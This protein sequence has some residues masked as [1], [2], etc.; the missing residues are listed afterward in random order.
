MRAVVLAAGRGSRLGVLTQD[1][2]KCFTPFR[3]RPLIH[4]QLEA[5]SQAGVSEIGVARGY[6]AEFWDRQALPVARYFTNPRWRETNMVASLA[7]AA[8]WLEQGPCLVSYSDIFY[9]ADSV[10]RLQDAAGDIVITY[11]PNWLELWRQRFADPLVDAETFRIDPGGR[12]L[13]IGAKPKSLAE[14][15]GQYMGLL[16]FTPA[17]WARVEAFRASLPAEQA[18]RLDMTGTLARL[19]AGGVE[20]RTVAIAERWYEIDQASDL[21]V[22]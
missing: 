1:Q 17:G 5:L 3:G 18:D 9:T 14:V 15:Q 16:K 19:L 11:D 21:A 4:W 22:V 13:E 20:I 10:R 12:L 6:L 2:P 7:C 8:Q